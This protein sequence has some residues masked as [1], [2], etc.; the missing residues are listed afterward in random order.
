MSESD[1]RNTD[2]YA[3]GRI[4]ASV[5][6]IQPAVDRY[7]RQCAA[8]GLQTPVAEYMDGWRIGYGERKTGGMM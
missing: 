2:W 8:Y 6:A 1:C 4:D 3:R 5:Y 7:A